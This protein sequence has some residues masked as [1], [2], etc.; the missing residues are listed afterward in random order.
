MK[1]TM[2]VAVH[3]QPCVALD[4]VQTAI[5]RLTVIA[6]VRSHAWITYAGWMG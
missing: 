5:A 6:L 4:A 3:V 2:I 1:R